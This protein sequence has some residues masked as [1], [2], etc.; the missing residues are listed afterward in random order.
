MAHAAAGDPAQGPSWELGKQVASG[1]LVELRGTAFPA[2]CP[3][4]PTGHE[5]LENLTQEVSQVLV[6]QE[7]GG[8]KQQER[9]QVRG[10][11]RGSQE[12]AGAG[13]RTLGRRRLQPAGTT[14]PCCGLSLVF[15][16]NS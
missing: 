16:A 8:G 7:R 10:R 15:Q 14:G 9:G 2:R 1:V 5:D 11:R 4:W 6:Q 12:E 3:H 13:E